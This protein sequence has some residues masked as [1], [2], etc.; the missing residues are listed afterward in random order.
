LEVLR[1]SL[2]IRGFLGACQ[3]PIVIVGP[4][5][6]GCECLREEVFIP[7]TPLDPLI[8]E[9]LL[10]GAETVDEN[11]IKITSTRQFCKILIRTEE[12]RGKYLATCLRENLRRNNVSYNRGTKLFII[13][14]YEDFDVRTILK[15]CTT[16][17]GT[18][19]GYTVSERYVVRTE[20]GKEFDVLNYIDVLRP[21]LEEIVRS[22]P[23]CLT[24]S[25]GLVSH[26]ELL[27]M[28]S[29][30]KHLIVEML[31]D[32]LWSYPH[33]QVLSPTL[34]EM[35][36]IISKKGTFEPRCCAELLGLTSA[37]TL[38][39]LSSIWTSCYEL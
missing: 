32:S 14:I 38:L 24:P 28:T 1:R 2:E 22:I 9:L 17:R 34:S 3:L 21:V 25:I 12:H 30:A 26:V 8:T 36:S 27:S 31:V 6:V 19:A 37:L 11:I 5:K 18:V 23:Y 13:E 10:Q 16:Q 4:V 29:T 7:L 20:I 35:W 39:A 33:L 15:N